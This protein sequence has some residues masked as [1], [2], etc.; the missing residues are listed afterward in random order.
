V[1]TSTPIPADFAACP[2]DR[3]PG[4]AVCLRCRADAHRRA[5]ESR[6]RLATRL[7]IGVM[8][9]FGA[10][11][12]G[13]SA[14]GARLR[15]AASKPAAADSARSESFAVAQAGAAEPS[16]STST[17]ASPV[18]SVPGAPSPRVAAGQTPLQ[19][20]MSVERRGDSV[21][22]RFDTPAFRTRRRDKFE[23]VVRLTLP[24]IYGALAD[25]ALA[26]V[27]EGELGVGGDLLTEL[28]QRGLTL[29]EQDGWVLTL[30]PATRPGQD[31]PLVVSYR[32]TAAR[33]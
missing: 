28:P 24:A 33:P 7:G 1:Q 23:H 10:V 2:H 3:G 30:W 32:V 8:V 25:S 5:A 12:L 22:V 14:L 17:D 13:T 21:T 6:R 18:A 16:K 29:P 31:G 4:I 27:P 11:M 15:S 26:A 19:D 9:A 20:G